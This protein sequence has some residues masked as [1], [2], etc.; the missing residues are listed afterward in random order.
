MFEANVTGLA[1]LLQG[2]TRGSRVE[3]A[4]QGALEREA[5][6][7]ADAIRE[8]VP[9]DDG[10]LRGSVRVEPTDERLAVRVVAGGDGPN[11]KTSEAGVTYDEAL[12]VE[13]GTS[14][15][16]AQPFFWPTVNA[17][18][19]ELKANVGSA[20]LETEES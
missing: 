4:A 15:S 19:D 10:S 14:R 1:G 5:E 2:L 20:A 7:L 8:A 17:M 9:V 6:K 11:L 12:M 16:P 18:R 13:Y 3:D